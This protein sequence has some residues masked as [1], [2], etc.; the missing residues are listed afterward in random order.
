MSPICQF[1]RFARRI[2]SNG[3]ANRHMPIH[4]ADVPR[5]RVAAKVGVKLCTA[6]RTNS[7]IAAR[8]LLHYRAQLGVVRIEDLASTSVNRRRH[9]DASLPVMRTESLSIAIDSL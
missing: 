2:V 5:P 3:C 1:A 9:R 6:T 7:L 4:Q 8:A